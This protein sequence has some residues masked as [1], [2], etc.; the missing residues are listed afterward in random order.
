MKEK[1]RPIFFSFAHANTSRAPSRLI[2]RR[3]SSW[4]PCHLPYHLQLGHRYRLDQRLDLNGCLDEKGM[5]TDLRRQHPAGN[6]T[7]PQAILNL[8]AKLKETLIREIGKPSKESEIVFCGRILHYKHQSW[9]TMR[10]PKVPLTC[11]E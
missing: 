8:V 9:M 11:S 7:G 10:Q 1:N 3:R 4:I 5:R 6:H 2:A